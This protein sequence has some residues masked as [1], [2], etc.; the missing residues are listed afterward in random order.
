MSKNDND[1]T[2]FE[3]HLDAQYGKLGTPRRDAY[4]AGFED[5]KV[6]ELLHEARLKKGLTQAELAARCGTTKSYI[7]R[8]ENNLKEV[9][10]STLRR[11]IQD[12]LGGK[13]VLGVEV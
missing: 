6:G 5:F 7:S 3:A 13:L 1:I 8:I 10:I 12:G 2:T 11:I 4:E 9:R